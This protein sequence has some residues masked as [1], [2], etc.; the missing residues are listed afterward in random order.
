[1]PVSVRNKAIKTFR[2]RVGEASRLTFE[3]ELWA[4]FS[5]PFRQLFAK[6]PQLSPIRDGPCTD[7]TW[8]LLYFKQANE[9]P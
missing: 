1:V 8:L 9:P 3:F 7:P 2:V 6:N 4:E 5:I